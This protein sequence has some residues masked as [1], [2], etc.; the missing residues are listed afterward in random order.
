MHSNYPLLS[1]AAH[2]S[3]AIGNRS[4]KLHSE[5]DSTRGD[6]FIVRISSE[7]SRNQTIMY[8]RLVLMIVTAVLL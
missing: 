7:M 8:V 4:K 1:P 5:G 3:P 2:E 6:K